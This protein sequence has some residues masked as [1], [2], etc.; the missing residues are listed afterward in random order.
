[1]N[2]NYSVS[3]NQVTM[4]FGTYATYKG[5]VTGNTMSGQGSGNGT[6]NFIA[7]KTK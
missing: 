6:W 1:V 3:G 4:Q 5:T 2:G 7:A